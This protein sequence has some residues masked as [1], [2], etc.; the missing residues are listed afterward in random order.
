M[1]NAAYASGFEAC[2]VCTFYIVDVIFLLGF[3]RIKLIQNVVVSWAQQDQESFSFHI[4]SH[5]IQSL[6]YQLNWAK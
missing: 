6:N 5:K 2:V 3:K 4:F 1:E